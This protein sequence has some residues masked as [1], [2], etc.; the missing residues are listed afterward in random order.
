MV[1]RIIELANALKKLNNFSSCI[2]LLSALRCTPISRLKQTWKA[3]PKHAQAI[4][5]EISPIADPN[6]NYAAYRRL[7]SS[8][9]P[10]MV[11]YM[12]CITKDLTSIEEVPTMVN[13]QPGMVNWNKI[14][15]MGALFVKL[16]A[17]KGTHYT[18]QPNKDVI[19]FLANAKPMKEEEQYRISKVLEPSSLGSSSGS[20]ASSSSSTP[21]KRSSMRLSSKRS[22]A[23]LES[24]RLSRSSTGLLDDSMSRTRSLSNLGKVETQLRQVQLCKSC[25]SWEQKAKQKA[26]QHKKAENALVTLH[27][28]E[29][30]T[31]QLIHTMQE[32]SD[33]IPVLRQRLTEY[34]EQT[35]GLT[36]DLAENEAKVKQAQESLQAS[37]DRLQASKDSLSES[38][39][40]ILSLIESL[41]ALKQAHANSSGSL[42]PDA[43]QHERV[44]LSS[45]IESICKKLE[46]E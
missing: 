33:E 22:S 2:S 5:D 34:K 6:G 41:Q 4:F 11:P 16:A 7:E 29:L 25:G 21:T 39:Q 17:A 12:G 14:G 9:R 19:L 26:S 1:V 15:Q 40:L 23:R 27:Q 37:R 32:S 44:K 35:A 36:R 8:S 46:I 42:S 28:S 13:N 18:F 20:S 38:S 45:H 10:P 31:E 30:E 3:V 43:F 24:P